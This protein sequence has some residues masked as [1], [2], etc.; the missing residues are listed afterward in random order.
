M[1]TFLRLKRVLKHLAVGFAYPEGDSCSMDK[2][3]QWCSDTFEKNNSS[4][5][6]AEGG[7]AG[8][9]YPA[10]LWIPHPWKCS[11]LDWMEF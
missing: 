2:V 6:F 5:G 4:E 7:E 11:R 8:T 3:L 10:L 1:L 9:G